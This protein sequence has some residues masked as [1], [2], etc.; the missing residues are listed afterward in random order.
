MPR[1]LGAK[2]SLTSGT[3]C[4]LPGDPLFCGCPLMSFT[5]SALLLL[6]LCSAGRVGVNVPGGRTGWK[7]TLKGS[8]PVSCPH[9]TAT[10]ACL[11][12]EPAQPSLPSF[13]GSQH[14]SIRVVTWT[15]PVCR[16]GGWKAAEA[17]CLARF[18]A[19]PQG[20]GLQSAQAWLSV[21]VPPVVPFRFCSSWK[22]AQHVPQ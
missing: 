10:G 9:D 13:P 8:E 11:L 21:G 17:V 6:V 18:L 5:Y 20:P 19:R 1:A 4:L 22:E 2:P 7:D 14:R 12:M 16:T 3:G 15:T